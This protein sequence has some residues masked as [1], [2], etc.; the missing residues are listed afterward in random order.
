M[1]FSASVELSARL[2]PFWFW[3]GRIEA[4]VIRKQVALMA[5]Q[6]I[7]GFFIAPRQGLEVP[8]LSESWFA[9]VRVAVEAASAQGMQVWIYDEYPYPSGMAGGAVGVLQPQARH[10]TLESL[11][12]KV[13]GKEFFAHD[14]E[15]A[16]LLSLRA[17]P[18]DEDGHRDWSRNIDL[19]PQVGWVQRRQVFQKTGLTAYNDKRFFTAEPVMR[20]NWQVP[21]GQWEVY[22][23]FEKEIEDF[24]YFGHYIDPCNAEAVEQ[25]ISLTHERYADAVGNYFGKV[26]RGFFTD[27]TGFL[28]RLPWSP[29]LP[30]YFSKR[31][32][33]DLIPALPA[34]HCRN[35]PGFAKVRYDYWQTLHELLRERYHGRIQSWCREHGLL[36][37][38][39]TPS[40]RATTQLHADVPATDSGHEK[41]GASIR[42]V[43]RKNMY[44]LR[45]NPKMASSLASQRKIREVLVE[46]FHSVGW[47]MTLQ[48]AKWMVDR[49][50]AMGVN[51]FNPHAFFYT[52]DD[53]R[54]HD[55]P[56]SLFYQNPYWKHF[57]LLSDYIRHGSEW[58]SAGTAVCPIAVLDPITS[59]WTRMGNPMEDL[60]FGGDGKQDEQELFRLREDW[61]DLTSGLLAH[62]RDYQHL[63]PEM[64]T[65]AVINKGMLTLGHSIYSVIILP[66]L[67]NLETAAWQKLVEFAASGGTVIGT[68]HLPTEAIEGC[69][70]GV[71]GKLGS[72]FHSTGL[73]P[74]DVRNAFGLSDEALQS[75]WLSS[76]DSC[77]AG[78][79]CNAGPWR[80]VPRQ[81]YSL[82]DDW[83][84]AILHEADVRCA[85]PVS[86]LLG[87]PNDSLLM[88]SRAIDKHSLRLFVT[89]QAAES[90][91][92]KIR[93]D[94]SALSKLG[95]DFSASSLGYCRF[96]MENGKLEEPIPFDVKGPLEFTISLDGFESRAWEISDF[97]NSSNVCSVAPPNRHT[98]PLAAKWELALA[99]ENVLRLDRFGLSVD[100]DL[101]GDAAAIPFIH[102]CEELAPKLPLKYQQV[103]GTPVK[104]APRYPFD[105]SFDVKWMVETLPG[106]CAIV[107]EENSL[108]GAYDL[109]LNG[110]FFASS[111]DGRNF[112]IE[113]L[114]RV[115]ENCLTLKG[116]V[117]FD[118]DGLADAL[119]LEGDFGVRLLS[120][121]PP[122]LIALPETC[123]YPLAHHVPLPHYS[124]VIQ[125]RQ[126]LEVGT[127]PIGQFV[128]LQLPDGFLPA[129]TCLSL[130]VDGV[131][132]GTRA[133]GPYVW[134]FQLSS[135]GG[136]AHQIQ[137]RLC[138]GLE[139]KFEGRYFDA[140]RHRMMPRA[141]ACKK[142]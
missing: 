22:G 88:S 31:N 19:L 42:A 45:Y 121:R 85:P 139:G 24:K 18:V 66:P 49:F 93:L 37:I 131:C 41:L 29:C 2:L 134:P 48:D 123:C 126:Y 69:W 127:V 21:S 106:R 46:C 103:F 86:L 101:W 6:G 56:P 25:F 79:T 9:L 117:H 114:L 116:K 108:S 110:E 100:G 39:E 98:L 113:H 81:N 13:T 87:E 64:L 138:T 30:D 124:G 51:C 62:Q 50:L 120:D 74:L 52:T 112:R 96:C 104:I 72:F 61:V 78:Q 130:I 102:Q 14:F 34:L 99:S 94:P 43:N 27:E 68:G 58:L 118:E 105:V 53:L 136:R 71:G 137:L 1:A 119:Y 76:V 73:R 33:Y 5:E 133:W 10:R 54:K 140:D 111:K 91:D 28:G 16:Q 40:L 8:Y 32:G 17:V 80:W 90:V 15:V 20:L 128:F 125:L 47:S 3:N 67:L 12:V 75:Y 55:A 35:W 141:L 129:G 38:A 92:G 4:S 83:V 23:Y 7:G 60:A 84:R 70:S 44:S 11:R 107:W 97:E 122:C 89:N 65:Q 142:S 95:I 135:N 115:G 57:H 59:F 109:A 26:I 132:L 36:Y 77:A 63:D 82:V